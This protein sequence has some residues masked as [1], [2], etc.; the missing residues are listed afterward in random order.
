MEIRAVLRRGSVIDQVSEKESE[1]SLRSDE[2]C[3]K[4]ARKWKRKRGVVS[5]TRWPLFC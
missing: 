4:K 3:W 2:K 1:A 5:T